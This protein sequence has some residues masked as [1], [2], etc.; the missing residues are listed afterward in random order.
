MTTAPDRRAW[1]NRFVRNLLLALIPVAVVWTVITPW[2]NRFVATAGSNLV[3]LIESPNRTRL[4]PHDRHHAV[5]VRNDINTKK[6]FLSSIRTT[7]IHFNW[8]MFAV[9][10]LA[11]PTLPLSRRL[12]D[13]GV[14]TLAMALFHVVLAF[15][16]VQ[17]ILTN[18]LGSW[19]TSN[20]GPFAQNAWGLAKH[21]ADLPFKFG[22][23]LA[24]WAALHLRELPREAGR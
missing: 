5:V 23:P 4:V 24:V 19:S 15:L 14:G 16:W 2:Y 17:F 9:L 12:R 22:L 3:Q 8:I 13:L 6:G 7:D 1:F 21:L 10:V 11:T 18:Q 20:Y